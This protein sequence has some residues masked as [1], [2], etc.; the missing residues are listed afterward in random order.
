VKWFSQPV[1]VAEPETIETDADK[2]A[3]AEA[4]MIFAN[5]GYDSAVLAL[6]KHNLTHA[7]G[8]LAY[9]NAD[10]TYIQTF[11]NDAMRRKLESDL[12]QS[13]TRRNAALEARGNLLLKLGLIR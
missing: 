2:L 6:R 13:L 7:Q 4:E 11:C 1:A 5:Q 10:T 8:S 9:R 12:R 3:H